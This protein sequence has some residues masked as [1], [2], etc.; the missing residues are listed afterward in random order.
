MH[1]SPEGTA[2]SAS[3]PSHSA[4]RTPKPGSLG[5]HKH[6]QWDEEII[7]EHDL[8]RGTRMKIDEPPTPFHRRDSKD[9]GV[10]PAALQQCLEELQMNEQGQALSEAEVREK[11]RQEF[12]Q[13]RRQHYNE[14]DEVK[15][16]RETRQEDDED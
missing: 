4:L 3:R 10:S 12:E 16:M 7:A 2:G 6:L 9:H 13:R 11:K 8:E 15:R 14:F 5:E 1:T